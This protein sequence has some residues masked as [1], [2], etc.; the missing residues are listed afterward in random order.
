M[1][2]A[3]SAVAASVTDSGA[4]KLGGEHGAVLA[5]NQLWRND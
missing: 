3:V 2:C 4:G 5:M 1:L